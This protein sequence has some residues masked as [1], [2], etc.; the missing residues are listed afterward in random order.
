MKT[1]LLTTNFGEDA[2]HYGAPSM[3]IKV[4]AVVLDI[5]NILIFI[6]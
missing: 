5:F 4:M 2:F 1:Y 3:S 6:W